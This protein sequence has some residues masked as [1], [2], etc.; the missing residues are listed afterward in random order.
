MLVLVFV[1]VVIPTY[2]SCEIVRTSKIIAGIISVNIINRKG[3]PDNTNSKAE[4]GVE[5]QNEEN[6]FM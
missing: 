4:N 2:I 1:S 6:K 3:W 5:N